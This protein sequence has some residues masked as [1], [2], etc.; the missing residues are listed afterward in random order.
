MYVCVQVRDL[1]DDIRDCC[2]FPL[3]QLQRRLVTLLHMVVMMMITITISTTVS[4][5]M[6]TTITRIMIMV[7][8]MTT[9]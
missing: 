5:V 9:R 2:L 7:M 4:M 6:I 3:G 8:I 1:A